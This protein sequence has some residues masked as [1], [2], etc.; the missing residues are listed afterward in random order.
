MLTVTEVLGGELGCLRMRAAKATLNPRGKVVKY[1]PICLHQP[2]QK[3]YLALV[4]T[5]GGPAAIPSR[6]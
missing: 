2:K 3:K 1:C 6:T 4:R 5:V